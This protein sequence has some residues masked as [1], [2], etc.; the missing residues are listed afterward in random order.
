M[1]KAGPVHKS[2]LT[3]GA[4]GFISQK[5]IITRLYGLFRDR[6]FSKYAK[7]ALLA[8]LCFLKLRIKER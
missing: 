5:Q 3:V 7:I 2:F 6:V 8:F 1:M 4:L